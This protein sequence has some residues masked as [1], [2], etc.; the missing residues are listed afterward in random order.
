MELT[1][2]T[3]ILKDQPSLSDAIA[4]KQ[5]KTLLGRDHKQFMKL[6]AAAAAA[7]GMAYYLELYLY[8]YGALGVVVYCIRHHFGYMKYIDLELVAGGGLL[9]NYVRKDEVFRSASI[10]SASLIASSMIN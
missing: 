3:P 4:A 7:A 6:A 10:I 1:V 5:G 9:S 8:F 2:P